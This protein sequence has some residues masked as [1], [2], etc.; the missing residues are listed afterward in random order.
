MI[1]TFILLK[2]HI[3]TL[4]L[5]F[6]I[7]LLKEINKIIFK[8]FKNFNTNLIIKIIILHH[9]NILCFLI[10]EILNSIKTVTFFL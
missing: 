5:I 1:L 7:L 3:F 10:A 4:L 9:F 6:N 2:D 8:I